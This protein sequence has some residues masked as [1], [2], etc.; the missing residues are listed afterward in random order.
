MQLRQ[1][2][3]L[4]QEKIENEYKDLLKEIARLEDILSDAR[5]VAA[6]IKADLKYIKG[7]VRRR[8]AHAHRAAGGR[9]DQHRGPHR[10]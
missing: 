9:G 6:I 1:L 8:A 2:T 3:G 4:E 10:R 7:Q 5:R